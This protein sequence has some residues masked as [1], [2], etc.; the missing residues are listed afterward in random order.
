MQ[1]YPYKD[2]VN[3]SPS[4]RNLMIVTESMVKGTK[5]IFTTNHASQIAYLI[6]DYTY[7]IPVDFL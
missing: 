5:F 4:L 7:V 6:K 2:I 1:R 3:Y